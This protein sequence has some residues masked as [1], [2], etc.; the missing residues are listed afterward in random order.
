M[1]LLKLK[2]GA[3]KFCHKTAFLSGLYNKFYVN[4]IG[5]NV[6][7]TPISRDLFQYTFL[8]FILHTSRRAS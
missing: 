3:Q 8:N 6:I 7:K 5:D 4:V 1:A 2:N